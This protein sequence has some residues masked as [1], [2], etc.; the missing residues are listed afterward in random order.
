MNSYADLNC[1]AS[2]HDATQMFSPQSDNRKCWK[3]EGLDTTLENSIS[4]QHFSV[5]VSNWLPNLG[6]RSFFL[7]RLLSKRIAWSLRGA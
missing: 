6:S 3:A 1:I 4:K 2:L 5:K 7:F